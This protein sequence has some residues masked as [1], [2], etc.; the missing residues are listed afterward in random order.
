MNADLISKYATPVPRYTSYPTAPHFKESVGALQYVDWL[1]QIPEGQPL[2]LYVHIPYCHQLCWYCGCNT[3]ATRRYEPVQSYLEML[4]LEIEHVAGLV[5]PTQPVTHMHWGGGS[6]NIL[7]AA[8]I[9]R[10]AGALRDQFRFENAEFAVEIDPRFSDA[11]Q[12]VAF[13]AAGV[14]RVSIGVQDFDER[15]QAAIG[16]KQSFDETKLAIDRFR[17][18]GVA[19]VNL[20]LIY[21]LPRQTCDSL[22]GTLDKVVE[23]APERVAAFGYAH[24]PSRLHNQKLIDDKAL[25][26]PAERLA[27]TELVSRRLEQAGYARVGLDH[28]VEKADA[29][30]T[31]VVRRNFQGYTS[32]DA[33]ILIGLGASAIGR[34]PQGYVQNAVA[35]A[36]YATR[37]RAA[38][39]ATVRGFALS[40]EDRV[41]A[42]I[43]ER[44]MC[45]FAV[46]VAD[47]DERFGS[48]AAPLADEIRQLAAGDTDGL[49]AG[50]AEGI[51]ITE[52][53]RPFVRSIC[54]KFD[55]YLGQGMARHSGGV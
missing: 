43:I 30:A 40:A 16:R 15:V 23:L 45:D 26:V 20:D 46:S 22:S 32:D 8:D 27:Q 52:L 24:L 21:G 4:Q 35:V 39:V 38:G 55:A 34:L 41:R 17:D 49:L 1:D 6:P 31:K 18:Q 10:L 11:E 19:S 50:T 2:S 25:P 33:E 53:G 9:G 42:H 3:K 36:E 54:S 28:Y 7:K 44:L 29:L 51:R 5:K 13:A 12:V 48:S 47:L 37:I 14:T